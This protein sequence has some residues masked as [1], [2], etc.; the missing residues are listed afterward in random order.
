MKKTILLIPLILIILTTIAYSE[1][2]KGFKY[3]NEKFTLN[4]DNFT[5][6]LDI[7]WKSAIFKINSEPMQINVGGCRQTNFYNICYKESIFNTSKD[8]GRLDERTGALIPALNISITYFN[9][10]LKITKKFSNQ[11]PIVGD[12]ITVTINLSNEGNKKAMIELYDS[13]PENITITE[14]NWGI[15][16]EKNQL[17]YASTLQSGNSEIITY[18]FRINSET[19]NLLKPQLNYSYEDISGR[20][21]GTQTN[22]STIKTIKTTITEKLEL[23]VGSNDKLTLELYNQDDVMREAEFYLTLPKEIILTTSSPELKLKDQKYW[24]TTMIKPHSKQEIELSLTGI[25]IGDYAANITTK[26]NIQSQDQIE[27]KQIKIKISKQQLIPQIEISEKIF[28]SDQTI[29]ITAK[30]NN[31]DEKNDF[32]SIK[33][34]L[35]TPDNSKSVTLSKI[36]KNQD[37]TLFIENATLP[38]VEQNTTYPIN[39]TGTYTTL[40]GEEFNFSATKKILIQPIGEL[41]IIHH[42]FDKWE[43]TTG[44]VK[45]TVYI[46]NKKDQKSKLLKVYDKMPKEVSLV[47]G[48]MNTNMYV[49]PKSK[50]QAY[51]YTLKIPDESMADSYEIITNIGYNETAKHF[52]LQKTSTI[53]ALKKS[54]KTE[55]IKT[56]IINDTST[57][58]DTAPIIDKGITITLPPIRGQEDKSFWTKIKDFFTGIFS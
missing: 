28:S 36:V 58:I 22:F 11:T 1:D 56:E 55:E 50:T 9:P 52:L 44:I 6:L 20:I 51:S 2:F 41:L 29:K 53:N 38:F 3:P 23:P 14:K 40:T 16:N 18:K 33:T 45:L 21:Y 27:N 19:N 15:I 34:T 4:Q 8:L 35:N 7:S 49:E 54:V 12:E 47:E 31:S 43:N 42:E 26:S 17:L 39:F 5:I 37:I 25:L 48:I 13:L 46:E 57:Q 32:Y 30:I 24:I 10:K